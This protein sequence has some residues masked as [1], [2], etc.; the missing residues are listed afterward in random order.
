VKIRLGTFT[1]IDG[2][3]MFLFGNR[4]EVPLAEE[5]K[6]YGVSYPAY[7]GEKEGFKLHELPTPYENEYR[8]EV[9]LTEISNAFFVAT[10]AKYKGEIFD[11]EPY[12]GDEIHLHITTKNRE[13]GM[14]LNFY[15]LHDGH[16]K[17]Y[18]LN[19]IKISD[20]EKIWEERS[21]SSLDLSLP[22]GLE[23][24]KEIDLPKELL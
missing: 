11:V 10:K 5:E 24:R 20:V 3:E 18:Y 4:S 17:P 1:N 6:I 2:I 12:Y 22:E 7:L 9:Y 19:E 23:F 13:L 21:Q 15:E 14:K 8:K 16:G